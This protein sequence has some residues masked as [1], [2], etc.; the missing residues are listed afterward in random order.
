MPLQGPLRFGEKFTCSV[1]K[2]ERVNDADNDVIADWCPMCQEVMCQN[3]SV[4]EYINGA[5]LCLSCVKSIGE[6][7]CRR[8]GHFLSEHYS[9]D[10]PVYGGHLLE[11]PRRCR[12]EM[13][14]FTS[15]AACDCPA[16][17][18]MMEFHIVQF[19]F[20]LRAKT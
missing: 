17:E 2:I 5:N 16:L 3:C 11:L 18:R 15:V 13:A 14:L 8:C 6:G 7:K 9:G 4:S 20:R 10:D 1:C 12:H 19:N